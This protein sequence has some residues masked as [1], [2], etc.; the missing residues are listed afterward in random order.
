LAASSRGICRFGEKGIVM[1]FPGH[2]AGYSVV[3]LRAIRWML[4]HEVDSSDMAFQ[5]LDPCVP[6]RVREIRSCSSR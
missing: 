6:M 2:F 4:I 3:D 1:R 5:K